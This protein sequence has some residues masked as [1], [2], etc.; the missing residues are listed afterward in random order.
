M[1]YTSLGCDTPVGYMSTNESR[2]TAIGV[3][4]YLSGAHQRNKLL[5]S[6]FATRLTLKTVLGPVQQIMSTNSMLLT[7]WQRNTT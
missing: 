5:M 6:G 1:P 2:R 7:G 3:I 4:R